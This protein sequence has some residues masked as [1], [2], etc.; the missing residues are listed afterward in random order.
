MTIELPVIVTFHMPCRTKME[1]RPTT[2]SVAI[3]KNMA[4]NLLIGMAFIRSAKMV[5]DFD[6]HVV[7]AKALSTKPF[8]LIY[9]CP[10]R[11]PPRDFPM[12][13]SSNN[14]LY[15]DMRARIASTY[16]MF[17]NEDNI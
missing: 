12:N 11:D 5:I 17:E 14:T 3:G 13:K 10:Q 15:S 8:D 2:F 9:R 4:I 6:D 7:E 16:K 1:N